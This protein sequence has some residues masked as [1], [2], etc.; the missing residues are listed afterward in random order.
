[1]AVLT[2]KRVKELNVILKQHRP[3]KYAEG[4]R[5]TAEGWQP[6][7][8][9]IAAYKPRKTPCRYCGNKTFNFAGLGTEV[10]PMWECKKCDALHNAS[11]KK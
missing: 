7:A 6:T 9:I 4:W 11:R 2:A 3:D 8:A 1:M 5:A 10:T